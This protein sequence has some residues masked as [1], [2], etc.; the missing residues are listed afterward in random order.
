MHT[1]QNLYSVTQVGADGNDGE[2]WIQPMNAIWPR[3]DD[4]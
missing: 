1:T 3:P 2:S 4:L